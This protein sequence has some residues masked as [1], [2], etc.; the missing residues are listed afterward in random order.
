M[1]QLF[2]DE[3]PNNEISKPYLKFETIFDISSFFM[4]KFAKGNNSKNK[5]D[6]V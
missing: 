2:F 5:S 6:V 4:T 3:E 1:G